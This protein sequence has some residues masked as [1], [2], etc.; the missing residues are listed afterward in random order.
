M[1]L[2]N[3]DEC[4]Q[5]VIVKGGRV[6]QLAEQCP[7]KAWVDGSSPS[8]LTSNP[9]GLLDLHSQSFSNQ[10]ILTHTQ[11]TTCEPPYLNIVHLGRDRLSVLAQHNLRICVPH[12]CEWPS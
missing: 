11:P 3:C 2:G 8:A 4:C 6:A 1:Q 5:C 9:L 10:E 7:F 12:F